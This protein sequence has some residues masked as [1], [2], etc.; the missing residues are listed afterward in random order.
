MDIINLHVSY[1]DYYTG[2]D[3]YLDMF[4]KGIQT[5]SEYDYIRIH[6]VY[7]TDDPKILFP[8]INSNENGELSAIIPFPQNRKLLFKDLFWKN[9][10]INVVIEILK[11]YLSDIYNPVFH[12]HNLFLSNLASEMKSVFG[13]KIIMHLHCLPWKF[14]SDSNNELFNQLYQLFSEK[15]YEDFKKEEESKVDYSAPDKIICIS[16]SAIDYLTNVHHLDRNKI[17]LVR[18]GLKI[19]NAIKNTQRQS[20]PPEILYAGKVSKDKGVYEMLN[21]LKIVKSRGYDF[22]LK[23]AGIILNHDKNRIKTKYSEINIEILGEIPFEELQQHYAACTIGIVPSLHEQ[24]CYVAM[25]MAAYGIPVTVSQVDG[26]A[27]IFEH[28][29]T[30]MLVPMIFDPDFGLSADTEKFSDHIIRLITDD[31]LRKKLSRHI[32]QLYA[33][34]YTLEQMINKTIKI[35]QEE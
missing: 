8:K 13:G 1:R 17:R 31:D 2:I 21:A 6:S 34:E 35:Y 28:E 3:R 30:A 7:L 26:L 27:E 22:K 11:P 20:T 14:L 24:F 23:L 25:E 29:R 4:R 15:K 32:R 10:Y 33:E 18:N 12:T 5:K 9:K 16:E 19:Q